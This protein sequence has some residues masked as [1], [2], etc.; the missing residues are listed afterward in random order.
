MWH[1]RIAPIP[2]VTSPPVLADSSS[3]GLILFLVSVLVVL[4]VA[5]AFVTIWLVRSTRPDHAVLSR[6]ETM[7]T[8]QWRRSRS[9]DRPH[10]GHAVAGSP[11]GEVTTKDPTPSGG[12]ERVDIDDDQSPED[13]G[14]EGA[15]APA[16]DDAEA[17]ATAG[18]DAD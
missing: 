8:A 17:P 13:D 7:G 6:L 10:G 12:L 15:D 18:G 3:S 16:G 1:G 2:T 4:G 9:A 5:M 11:N 14:G